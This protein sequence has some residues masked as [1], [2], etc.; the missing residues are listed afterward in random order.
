MNGAFKKEMKEKVLGRALEERRR[1]ASFGG[2]PLVTTA[3]GQVCK[4]VL[5]R[6][7]LCECLWGCM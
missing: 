7:S 3:C 1:A 2:V 6:D 5:G 4:P